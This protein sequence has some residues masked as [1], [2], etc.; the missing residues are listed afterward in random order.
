ME[1]VVEEEAKE[2][3]GTRVEETPQVHSA[4]EVAV[5]A[6]ELDVQVVV[7]STAAENIP[8]R[9]PKS[10][11]AQRTTIDVSRQEDRTLQPESIVSEKEWQHA[12]PDT[13]DPLLDNS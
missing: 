13:V 5:G 6:E 7:P 11:E 10:P 4:N 3:D 2:D 12:A 1:F 8:T 9:I